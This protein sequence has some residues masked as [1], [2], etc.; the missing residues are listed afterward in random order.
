MDTISLLR[1][2][3]IY[4]A[5][6]LW[7]YYMD[8]GRLEE[9]RLLTISLVGDGMEHDFSKA[10]WLEKWVQLIGVHS[11]FGQVICRGVWLV[12]QWDL[13]TLGRWIIV[14]FLEAPG[15]EKWV[16]KRCAGHNDFTLY[17]S[18]SVVYF[19]ILLFCLLLFKVL[20]LTPFRFTSDYWLF[21]SW[22]IVAHL[23]FLYLH[24]IVSLWFYP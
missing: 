11:G 12:G 13:G 15:L 5:C 7:L 9:C 4:L 14:S 22:S 3:C 17:L 23:F 6:G 10:T 1:R 24:P 18:F 16:D 8:T 2:P 21:L 20:N 19:I